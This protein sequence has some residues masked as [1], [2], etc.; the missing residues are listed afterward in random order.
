[1]YQMKIDEKEKKIENLYK[2]NSKINYKK[3]KDRIGK[4]HKKKFHLFDKSVFNARNR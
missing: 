1:M 2:V 4:L 3:E